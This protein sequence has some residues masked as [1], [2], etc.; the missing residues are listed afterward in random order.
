MITRQELDKWG[1][2][3][4]YAPVLSRDTKTNQLLVNGCLGWYQ[5]WVH[6]ED[7]SLTPCLTGE[8][9]GMI[10]AWENWITA[11]HMNH[12]A[13]FDTYV[14]VGA[15]VGYYAFLAHHFGKDV[16]AYE[17]DPEIQKLLELS[18]D[19]NVGPNSSDFTLVYSGVSSSPGRA[20]LVTYE[21]FEG[22]TSVVRDHAGSIPVTSLDFS[23]MWRA[24]RLGRILIKMDI[25]SHEE[26]AWDGAA[27]LNQTVKPTYVIEWTPGAYS[28]DF[29]KKLES[30]GQV[31]RITETG[32]EEHCPE[33][34]L[35][36][37]R[38]WQM[39]VVRPHA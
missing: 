1:A 34:M 18:V 8:V 23:L 13:E 16:F 26:F 35:A 38:D 37:G 22:S 2:E 24:N 32:G 25:E 14:D 39:I 29:Y 30:Y 20:N 6:A 7:K 11:W 12:F 17:A 31:T 9:G 15:N 4:P 3:L 10:G 5:L 21:G 19:E 27:R 28:Q 36:A 33:S